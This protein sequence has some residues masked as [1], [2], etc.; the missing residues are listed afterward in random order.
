MTEDTRLRPFVAPRAHDRRWLLALP[1]VGIAVILLLLNLAGSQKTFA[2]IQGAQPAFVLAV[3]IGQV[4]RYAASAGSTQTL[5]KTFG[6]HLPSLPLYETML[7]GQALNRTFSVGGAAGMW[8]RYSFLTRQ[9]LHSGAVAAL[10]VVEDV[11]GAVAISLVFTAGFIAVITTTTLPQFTWIILS[12][13]AFALILIGLAGLNLYRRRALLQRIVHTIARTFNA[14]FAR[15]IGKE[16]Y[17][18]AHIQLAIDDFYVGMAHARRD[19]FRLSGAF[20]FN[21]LR[22]GLDAAS[23]YFAFWA[24]GFSIAPPFLLVIFTSSSAL[25]TLSGVP[26]ELG[27]M[28]TALAL[29]STSV[30]IPPPTAVSAILLFR[31]LSYW[32]PIPIGYLAFWNLERRGLI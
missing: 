9:E 29:L 28:E 21:L 17:D 16:V 2:L 13:F 8:A 1:L 5:A 4:L 31:A 3:L 32:L 10:F 30:G 18:P 20:L 14:V 27:V 25:S 6:Q 11:L 23:L 24:I 19:P 12:G 7:A 22:L 26:G 15:L